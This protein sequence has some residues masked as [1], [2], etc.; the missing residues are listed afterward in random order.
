MADSITTAQAVTTNL[1]SKVITGQT[2][3][4]TEALKT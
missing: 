4:I 2:Q 1:K 3:K